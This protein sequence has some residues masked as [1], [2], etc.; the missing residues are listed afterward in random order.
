MPTPS[1]IV[2]RGSTLVSS[3]VTGPL[4]ETVN[5][6]PVVASCPTVP[7]KVSVV[8]VAGV[9]AVAAGVEF[10]PH[11]TGTRRSERTIE[12]REK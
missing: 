3:I 6:F 2:S 8:L 4:V 12:N 10:D 11:A 1:A 7:V 9:G 5:A